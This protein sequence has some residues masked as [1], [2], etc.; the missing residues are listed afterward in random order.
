MLTPWKKSYNKPRQDFKKQR[1][2]FATKVRIVKAMVFPVVWQLDRKEGWAPKT[3]CFWTMVLE[4]TLESPLDYKTKPV[5]PKGNQ[6]WIFIDRTKAE[7]PLLWPPDAKSRLTGKDPDAG[8]DWGQVEKGM[9]EDKMVGWYHHFSGHEFEQTS[10][11]CEGQEGLVYC[12]PWDH[13]ELDMI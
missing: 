1:H 2:R 3:W 5:N 4:K 7:S 8:K 9:T 11:D 13:K 10:G 6:P 12:S